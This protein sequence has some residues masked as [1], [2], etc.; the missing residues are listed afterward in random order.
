MHAEC[1]LESVHIITFYVTV[2][3]PSLIPADDYLAVQIQMKNTEMKG[4]R[5]G[6]ICLRLQTGSDKHSKDRCE[7]QK[8]DWEPFRSMSPK[9]PLYALQI[10]NDGVQA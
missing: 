3:L 5:E 8:Y 7:M 2:S 10:G 4:K 1:T 9:Y 6:K